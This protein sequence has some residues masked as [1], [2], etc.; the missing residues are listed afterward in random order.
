MQY[1]STVL[2]AAFKRL[3]ELNEH[4]SKTVSCRLD[5]CQTAL[6]SIIIVVYVFTGREMPR[7]KILVS[8]IKIALI[9]EC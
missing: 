9:N 2:T 4:A 8:V 7:I 1:C 6:V 3:T 5:V